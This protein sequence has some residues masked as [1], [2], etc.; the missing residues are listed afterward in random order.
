[1]AYNANKKARLKDVKALAVQVKNLSD[2]INDLE[3]DM[4]DIST[5]LLMLTNSVITNIQRGEST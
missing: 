3:A 2:R 5:A 4:Q 1:M